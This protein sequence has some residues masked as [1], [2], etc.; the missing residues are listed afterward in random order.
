MKL[1]PIALAA[2]ILAALAGVNLTPVAAQKPSA[3]PVDLE[4]PIAPTP[5]KAEGKIHLL[6]EVHITNFRARPLEL[7]RVDV[8]SGE[9]SAAPLASYSDSELASQ[10]VRPGAPP[11]LPNK[12]IIGGG[13]RAV[14]FIQITV[15]VEAEVPAVLR[16]RL[17]LKS[18]DQ[19]ASPDALVVE[20][21]AA[22]VQRTAPFVITSPLRGEGWIAGNGLSNTSEHRRA[23]VVVNGRARIAQRFAT[24]WVK[25]GP[26][27]QAF[28]GDPSKNANWYGYGTEVLAVRDGVVV[29]IKDGVPENDPTSDKKAVPITLETIGG[30]YVTLDLS[31]GRYAFYAHLQ[32]ASIRVKVGESVRRGQALGLLGNSGNSDAPHLHFQITDGSVPLGSEGLPFVFESFEVLGLLKSLDVL[33]NGKGWKPPSDAKPIVRKMEMPIDN[34]VVRFP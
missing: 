9:T 20:G 24:D 1:V 18:P 29:D 23:L 5:V 17:T 11:D 15:P 34:A 16:H 22:T 28:H 33:E 14:L 4:I 2:V 32:P 10:L 8:L 25:L 21:A 3:V 27:G 26:D 19:S 7:I 13:M 30:N 12:R 6:Y 31:G